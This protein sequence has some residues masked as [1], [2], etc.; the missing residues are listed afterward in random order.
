MASALVPAELTLRGLDTQHALT[1]ERICQV[2]VAFGLGMIFLAHLSG[3]TFV[4]PDLFHEMALAREF[5]TLGHM[6]LEDRFAYTPTVS[7]SVHHEWGTGLVLDL[8]AQTAGSTG[9][10]VLKYAL[11]VA[12][13]AGCYYCARRRGANFAT[14]AIL[15]TIP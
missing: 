5:L 10:M 4:D 13:V 11:T 14:I 12:V 8:V 2:A 7:P 1:R 15:C 6:P 9:I 3:L